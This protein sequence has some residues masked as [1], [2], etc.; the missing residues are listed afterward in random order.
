MWVVCRLRLGMSFFI[1]AFFWL[2]S[3]PIQG[4]LINLHGTYWPAAVFSGSMVLT[5]VA[6]ML[7][8]RTLVTRRTRRQRV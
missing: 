6:M 2:A 7:V 5:G 4:A 1:A 8:A 3:S